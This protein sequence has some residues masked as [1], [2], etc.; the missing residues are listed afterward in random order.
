ME[1]KN[2]TNNDQQ[3]SNW[4]KTLGYEEI[5]PAEKNKSKP[6]P[7]GKFSSTAQLAQPE[8]RAVKDLMD[9][10]LS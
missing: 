6:A 7:E 9:K 2:Q 4:M 5:V 10:Y 3:N 1:M 8:N